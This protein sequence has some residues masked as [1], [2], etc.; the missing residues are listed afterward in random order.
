MTGARFPFGKNW[1]AFLRVLS[2]ERIQQAERSLEAMI[3]NGRLS[4]TTFLDVGCGSGLFSL[5]AMRLGA[6]RVHSFDYDEDSVGCARELLRRFCPGAANWTIDRGSVLDQTYLNR[7][8]KWS[9]VYSWGVLHHTGDMWRALANAA[10]LV[11]PGGLLFIAIYNDQGPQSRMW[12]A[13]KRTFNR[14]RLGKAAVIAAFVPY[15]TG[16][17]IVTDVLRGT[18]PLRRYREYQRTRGMSM[19]R[20]WIDWL[21]GYP[22]EVA[23]PEQIFDFFRARGF[24]LEKL[25]TTNGLGCNEFVFRAPAAAPIDR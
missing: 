24:I 2:E 7:L 14:G 12:T 1:A 13:A 3:G 21:G 25:T 16:R 17:G 6:R 15:F 20:D 9:V 18:N 22:F 23:Q 19:V 5:A 8:G 4:G 10:A 11:E